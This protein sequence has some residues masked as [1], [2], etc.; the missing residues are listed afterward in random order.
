MVD[1]SPAAVWR[2]LAAVDDYPGWWPWLRRFEA[3]ALVDGERWSCTVKPPLP[4]TV[5]FDLVLHD[6]VARRSVAAEVEGEIVGSARVDLHRHGPGT[7]LALV[8]DLEPARTF[9]VGLSRLA[10]PVARYG[11]EFIIDSAL[12]QFVAHALE[13]GRPPGRPTS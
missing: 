3:R 8:S 4:Y 2:T 1:A 13:P 11:H 10:A 5:S 12:E 7:E 9:L 6:V